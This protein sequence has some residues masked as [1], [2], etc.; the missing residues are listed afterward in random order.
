MPKSASSSKH[1]IRLYSSP[2]GS[3][4]PSQRVLAVPTTRSVAVVD[5]YAD[6]S[7]AATSLLRARFAFGGQAP[8]APQMVLVNEYRMKD[9][10][11][12]IAGQASRYFA[13]QLEMTEDPGHSGATEARATRTSSRE[14]D[15]AGAETIISGSKGNVVIVN[16]RKSSV[17][18]KHIN[19]PL[20]VLHSVTSMDDAID[21]I[22]TKTEEPLA[23]L[24]VFG[25]PEVGKYASQFIDSHLCCVNDVPVELLVAPLTPV[26]FA[27]QLGKP[28]RTKMFSIPKPQLIQFGKRSAKLAAMLDNNDG[29]EAVKLRKQAQGTDTKVKHP[30]GHAVGFFEQGLMLGVSVALTTI[31]SSAV[32]LFKYGIPAIRRGIGH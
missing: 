26:G 27:T 12:A 20:L 25:S 31:V 5:R 22:N 17:L 7:A 3:I 9:L 16:D 1:C 15:Q 8:I 13:Q 30:A 19:E 24:L 2:D 18:K 21:F 4:A 11:T 14:L 29:K 10:C 23:A 6:M 28:Y 32:V